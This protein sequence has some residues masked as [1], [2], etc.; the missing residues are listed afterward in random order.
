[1][2]GA[3]EEGRDIWHIGMEKGMDISIAVFL[4][5]LVLIAGRY[6]F[7]GLFLFAFF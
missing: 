4:R 6:L 2:V 3:A 7:F 1:M 5:F